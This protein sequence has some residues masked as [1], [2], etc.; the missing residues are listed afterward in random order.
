V[1]AVA[2]PTAVLVEQLAT[3]LRGLVR[4]GAALVLPL[5]V[6]LDLGT[7]LARAVDDAGG[8]S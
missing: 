6:R 3:V 8:E 2:V 5:R 4:V 1:T 7:L